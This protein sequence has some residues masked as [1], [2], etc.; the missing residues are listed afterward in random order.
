MCKYVITYRMR[1]GPSEPTVSLIKDDAHLEAS[2]CSLRGSS[3]VGKITIYRAE[4][5]L[6]RVLQWAESEPEEPATTE[7]TGDASAPTASTPDSTSA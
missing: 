1:S 5:V 4:R 7:E 2:L 3:E 6:E